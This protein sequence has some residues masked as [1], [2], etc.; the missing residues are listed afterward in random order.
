MMPI[1]VEG[2]DSRMADGGNESQT[3]GRTAIAVRQVTKLYRFIFRSDYLVCLSCFLSEVCV[4]TEPANL[5][6]ASVDVF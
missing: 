4:R 6:A 3:M 2:E 5:L 1:L